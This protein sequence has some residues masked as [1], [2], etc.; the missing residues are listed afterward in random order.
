MQFTIISWFCIL[1]FDL[2]LKLKI[3]TL[4]LSI[5]LTAKQLYSK[6]IKHFQNIT[7]LSAF[8]WQFYGKKFGK[9]ILKVRFSVDQRFSTWGTRTPRAVFLKLGVATHLCV[10]KILLCVTKNTAVSYLSRENL[11]WSDFQRPNKYIF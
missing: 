7:I 11:I 8:L 5:W 2:K 10:A 3:N 1:Y 4:F 9:M 6:I